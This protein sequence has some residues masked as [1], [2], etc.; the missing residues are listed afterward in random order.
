[1]RSLTEARKLP[2]AFQLLARDGFLG[3]VEQHEQPKAVVLQE[4]AYFGGIRLC[5]QVPLRTAW[6]PDRELDRGATG[7]E[8]DAA[9]LA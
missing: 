2:V 3:E 4:L 6:P 9:V 5:Q 7:D 1:M 8:I